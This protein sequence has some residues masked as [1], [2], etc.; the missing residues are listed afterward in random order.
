MSQQ[1]SERVK[2]DKITVIVLFIIL[3]MIVAL[4]IR[5]YLDIISK[6][7]QVQSNIATSNT[8]ATNSVDTRLYTM[9]ERDR[10]EIYFSKFVTYIE[11]GQ[12]DEAYKLLY[13]DFKQNYFKTVGEFETYMKEKYPKYIAVEYSSIERQGDIYVLYVDITNMMDKTKTSSQRI[14]V[15]ENN[16]D[17]FYISF[18]II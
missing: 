10:M 2:K 13:P 9:T 17:D 15:K 11:N 7:E 18:Q 3:L 6:D 4:N 14:V 1:R 8:V 5:I 16:F 12:Y